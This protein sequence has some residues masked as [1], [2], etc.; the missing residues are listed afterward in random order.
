MPHI[1][2][3]ISQLFDEGIFSPTDIL[4]VWG[5]RGKGKSTFMG[6]LQS[7]LM[8]PKNAKTRIEM[9][10]YKCAKLRQADIIIDPPEDHLVFSDTFF[11]DNGFGGRGRRPYDMKAT[12]FVIPNATHRGGLICPCSC[13]FW[14]EVQDL[15]DSH[16]GALPTFVTKAFELS[17]HIGVFICMA[18]QRPMR[19]VKDI[20]DLA[21]FVEV[22][23][24][25]HE[26]FRG[27]ITR[28]VFTLNIIYD[29][30][31]FE[32]YDASADES[33]NEYIDK[34]IR[35]AFEGNIY[36]CLDT[37]YFMPVFY[38]GCENMTPVYNKVERIEF[39]PEGFERYA[40]KRTI[41]IPETFRGKKS[42]KKNTTTDDNV[43]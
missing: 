19:I 26:Y 29:N 28:S 17:R 13:L 5:K 16:K 8:K 23:S 31:R 11:E 14:D 6:K 7:D 12:D 3:D 27:C 30:S 37:D 21:T 40:S 2:N 35:V 39:S 15:Y 36:N 24:V 42:R 43:A 10:K 1:Y 32:A 4:I 34:T 18:C 20:R 9:A 38:K 22:V 41:D 25:K 33:K